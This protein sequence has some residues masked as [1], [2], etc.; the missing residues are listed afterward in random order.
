VRAEPRFDDTLIAAVRRRLLANE[1]VRRSL[2]AGGRVNV[3]RQLPFLVIY[4]PPP[5]RDDAGTRDF[6]R[7]EASYLLAPDDRRYRVRTRELARE[8]AGVMAKSFGGFLVIEVWAGDERGARPGSDG[9]PPP[10]AFRVVTMRKF[11]ESRTVR[12]LV[13]SLGKVVLFKQP[14]QVDLVPGGR[15]GAHGM[16]PLV[17]AAE[18]AELDAQVIGIEVSPVYRDP[19]TG[20]L[21]PIAK[22]HLVRQVSRALRL[23]AFEFARTETSARPRHYQ[24]LGTQALTKAAW[25]VDG[26]LA[27]LSSAFDLLLYVSP[28]NADAAFH[29]FKRSG[30]ERAPTFLYRPRGFDPGELKRRLYSIDIDRVE[31]PTMAHIFREK[32][33]DLDL[34]VSLLLERESPRF[35]PISTA[36]YG[37]IDE[38]LLSTARTILDTLDHEPRPAKKPRMVPSKMLVQRA[39]AEFAN[40]RSAFPPF[41]STIEVRD[42]LT[43][44]M[45]SQGNLLVGRRMSFLPDR[46]EPLL[47]HE[48]GTHIVTHWNG[49]AQPFKL[50]SAGLAHYDELQ[51]GLAVFA[52]YLAAG[53]TAGRMRTLAARVLAAQMVVDGAELVET[54]RM[55]TT[56]HRF[57]DRAAFLL[58]MRVHRGGGFVKDSV[59]LRGVQHVL[60]YLADGGHLETL[61]VGKISVDHAPIIEELQRRRVLRPS[62]LRPAYLDDP[63]GQQRLDAARYGLT[64]LDLVE[65]H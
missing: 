31:D 50:L 37:R 21:Y 11:A 48:V 55:L 29:E 27:D 5:G 35:L 1:R 25:E 39:E 6:A 24:A 64:L 28:T 56:E 7:S 54:W 58:A 52:E 62:P 49:H 18:L 63:D 13:E 12:T 16:G 32:R 57:A 61:L 38:S 17:T 3:D 40:Y 34:K 30:F 60:D 42:D 33:G 2:P 43:A 46:V 47:Q 10:P 14:A 53:L 51:E 26:A 15:I 45:V 20:D 22:R 8:V 44:L 19:E 59:Y 23:A 41:N 9:S 65:R 36:L 4:R